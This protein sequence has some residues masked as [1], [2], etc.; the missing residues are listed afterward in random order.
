V[1]DDSNTE[2]PKTKAA[3][4]RHALKIRCLNLY[5]EGVGPTNIARELGVSY[6]TVRNWLRAEGVGPKKN[7]HAPNEKLTEVPSIEEAVESDKNQAVNDAIKLAKAEARDMEDKSILA[8]AEA[9]STPADAYQ[10]YIAAAALKILRDNIKGIRPPRTV[11]ELVELDALIAKRLGIDAKGGGG[12]G[13]MKIDIAILNNVQA[14]NGGGA[15]K[16]EAPKVVA[17]PS[18]STEITSN[19]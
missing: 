17:L 15:L 2:K 8:N 4:K 11:K 19:E 18:E 16:L 10:A 3:K 6:S 1:P 5:N 7:Q 12:G 13:P 14:D 9:Q